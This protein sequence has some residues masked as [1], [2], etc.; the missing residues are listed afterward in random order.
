VN[1]RP[2]AV[3]LAAAAT[4]LLSVPTPADAAQWTRQTFTTRSARQCRNSSQTATM[5]IKQE[6]LR[7]APSGG[8]V[9]I[10]PGSRRTTGFTFDNPCSDWVMAIFLGAPADAVFRFYAAPG[11]HLKWNTAQAQQAGIKDGNNGNPL[12]F[13]ALRCNKQGRK[14]LVVEANGR[15]HANKRCKK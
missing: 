10:K 4:A 7:S 1:H 13:K 9:L 8:G 5:A 11:A 6:W 3:L 2:A 15:V 14:E 12:E